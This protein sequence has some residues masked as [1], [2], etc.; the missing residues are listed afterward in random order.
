MPNTRSKLSKRINTFDALIYEAKRAR[1]RNEE[2]YDDDLPETW[3]SYLESLGDL[4][5]GAKELI[6][7]IDKLKAEN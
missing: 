4:K 2:A 6:K 1:D 3:N 7:L 5:K